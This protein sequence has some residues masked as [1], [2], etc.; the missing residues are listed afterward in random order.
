MGPGGFPVTE[1]RKSS[2]I[3]RRAILL[4]ASA[5]IPIAGWGA[6]SNA[7]LRVVIITG[8]NSY[9]GHVWKETSAELKNILQSDERLKVTL[10]TDPNYLANDALF[11]YD[12]AVLDF[13][14]A[15]PL[16]SD[17]KV[18]ANLL[19]FLGQGKGLVVIHWADGAFPYWPEFTNI[20][21]RSQQAHHD[22]RGP[23][24]VKI[25]DQSDPI[26]HGMKDFQTDDELYY[27]FKEGDRPIKI[28]ATAHSKVMDK[29]FP[30]AMT[31]QYGKGRVFNTPLGHDV[32]GLKTPEVAELIRRGA[33]WA[34]GGLR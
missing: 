16:S 32:K 8:M 29:D 30:M 18:K 25:V 26:T 22:K 27:D 33:L 1:K 31:V 19:K 17:D 23:F 4:L 5:V 10:E 3:A 34:A 28:L 6:Q 9:A 15:D 7:P 20:V 13:R 24:E 11:G 21:G 2:I 14:N 12:A